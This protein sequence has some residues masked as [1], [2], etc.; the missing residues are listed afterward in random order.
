MNMHQEEIDVIRETYLRLT[1]DQ[2]RAGEIFYERLFE[3][4]P[5]TRDMF[6]V[7]MPVQVTKLMSTLGLVVSQL[8]NA[9]ALAPIV[10]DLALRHL[11]YGV[12]PEHYAQVGDALDA[13]MQNVLEDAYTDD[14]RRAW[15]RAYDG[16]SEMMIETAYREIEDESTLL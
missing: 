15:R 6:I 16:L 2:Q 1:T 11:A 14:A 3:L 12:K 10:E 9:T 7:D 4:A 5:E 8:H 13:M